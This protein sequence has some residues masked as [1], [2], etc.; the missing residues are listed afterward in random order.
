MKTKRISTKER[1]NSAPKAGIKPPAVRERRLMRNVPLA[2]PAPP[3][4]GD[5]R[6]ERPMTQPDAARGAAALKGSGRETR[7]LFGFGSRRSVPVPMPVMIA[8]DLADVMVLEVA[9]APAASA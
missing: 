5:P 9:E 1:P 4:G 8:A 7:P 2:A 6:L 3:H